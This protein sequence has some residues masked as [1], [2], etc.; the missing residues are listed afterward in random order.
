[1]FL[2]KLTKNHSKLSMNAMRAF[3]ASHHEQK[4]SKKQNTSVNV[5]DNHDVMHNIEEKNIVNDNFLF[6]IYGRAPVDRLSD[7]LINDKPNKYS[8]YY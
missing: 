6:W 5:P 2:A 7:K 8:A 3:G 4:H 1:M